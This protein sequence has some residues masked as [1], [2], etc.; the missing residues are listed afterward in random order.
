MEEKAITSMKVVDLKEKL[1]ELGLSTSGLK[2]V[3]VERLVNYYKSQENDN[4]G[5]EEEPEPEP[6]P[7]REMQVEAKP[8]ESTQ[9]T[10]VPVGNDDTLEV[11]NDTSNDHDNNTLLTRHLSKNAKKKRNRRKRTTTNNNDNNQYNNLNDS[12]Y[13]MS[14]DTSNTEG[15][16]I[17]YVPALP[18]LNEDDPLYAQFADVL[19]KFD[20]AEIALQKKADEEEE[21]FG[22]GISYDE[23]NNME[24]DEFSSSTK[25]HISKKSLRKLGRMTVAELKQSVKKPEVVDVSNLP[26]VL[27]SDSV[28]NNYLVG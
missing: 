23:S 17:D 15:I 8:M 25:V 9:D 4:A 14:Q 27:F 18:E 21:V 28:N 6:E 16:E 1:S 12:H 5:P 10:E 24:L 13:Q 2:A 26:D 3:L 11:N 7:E 19:K 20:P 22:A